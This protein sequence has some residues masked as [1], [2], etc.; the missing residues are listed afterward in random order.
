MGPRI[1][2]TECKNVKFKLIKTF[3]KDKIGAR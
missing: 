2:L 3:K 1:D